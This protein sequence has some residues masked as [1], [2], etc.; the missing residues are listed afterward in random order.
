M[1][2]K[3]NDGSDIGKAR[4]KSVLLRQRKIVDLVKSLGFISIES[5]STNFSVTPQTI[6]RDINEL[7]EAGLLHRHHGGAGLPSSVK[8]AAYTARKVMC[9]PEKRRIA[10]LL[11]TQIPNNASLFIDI[12]TTTEEVANA[13]IHHQGLRIITN[14]LNVATIMSENE[15]FQVIVA[16]GMVRSRDRGI[17]GKAT[18]DFIRQFKI[19]FGIISVSGI[20]SEGC[21]LDFDFQ[22]VGVGQTIIRNSRKVYLVADHTKFGR[23]AM[24]RLCNLRDIDALFTDQ[25]PKPNI[26]RMLSEADVSLHVATSEEM[27]L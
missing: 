2:E 16:G 4:G 25:M 6:R 12:G 10:R 22:E 15:N 13:L 24:V 5:L 14:N 26:C 18:V 9:M 11:A 19:D 23:E 20:D 17:T 21:L 3:R 27:L 8:N 1:P 7:T